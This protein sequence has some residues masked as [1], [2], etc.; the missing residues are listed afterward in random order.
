MRHR[1]A[2]RRRHFVGV[3]RAGTEDTVLGEQIQRELD[4]SWDI[5]HVVDLAGWSRSVD[6]IRF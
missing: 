2:C 4:T 3:S 6:M 5:G 1:P